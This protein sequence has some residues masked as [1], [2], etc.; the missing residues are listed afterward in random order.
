MMAKL[1][2]KQQRFCDE[3]LI[4]L[5]ATQA[6]IRAGYSEKN[7]RNI[8]SENLAKPN[9]R[10]YIDQR[11]A[12]K[13]SALI[14]DQDEVLKYLTSVLRGETRSEV[15]V[16]ENIG[17]YMSEARTMKKAPDEKERLKAAELLGKRYGLYTDRVEQEVDMNLN[18]T[19]DYG[20]EE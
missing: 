4:D 13:E 5:N 16:V 12:E 2:A 15:V 10:A 19:V 9:I 14:A 3:Y 18:I 17:D 8:A 1:T 7:A 11:M 6:A 20:D